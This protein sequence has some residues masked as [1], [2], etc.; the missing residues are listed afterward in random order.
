MKEVTITMRADLTLVYREVPDNFDSVVIK[1]IAKTVLTNVLHVHGV[2][3]IQI[4][5]VKAFEMVKEDCGDA[6]KEYITGIE[7]ASGQTEENGC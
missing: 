2:D 7:E 4:K 6:D 5:N 1:D 3:D